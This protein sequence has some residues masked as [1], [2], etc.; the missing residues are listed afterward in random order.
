VIKVG[1]GIANSFPAAPLHFAMGGCYSN[2]S[3]GENEILVDEHDLGTFEP[4][5]VDFP[6][7]DPIPR[8]KID[9]EGEGLVPEGW[10]TTDLAA[11][12]GFLL[13]GG[14]ACVI[15][16][17]EEPQYGAQTAEAQT[18]GAQTA[19]GA[20]EERTEPA[21][22]DATAPSARRVL[23]ALPEWAVDVPRAQ[24]LTR[25]PPGAEWQSLTRLWQVSPVPASGLVTFVFDLPP[26][27]AQSLQMRVRKDAFTDAMA[28]RMHG[29][30]LRLLLCLPT[31]RFW[32]LLRQEL[33]YVD[34]QGS[35]LSILPLGCLLN[36]KGARAAI[37]KAPVVAPELRT[38]VDR[39]DCSLGTS[40]GRNL[41]VDTHAVAALVLGALGAGGRGVAG[42]S[43]GAQDVLA[44]MLRDEPESRIGAGAALCHPWLTSCD[45]DLESAR[46][47]PISRSGSLSCR[48]SMLG[49]HF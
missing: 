36:F 1:R 27:S 44:K 4:L 9:F 47:S 40:R 13:V 23:L 29:N 24:W 11:P 6:I 5:S 12:S 45:V 30:L 16:M 48:R 22:A 17:R 32:G 18:A 35:L 7:D 2:S 21:K 42:L 14:D 26:S 8:K 33:V 10:R 15:E 25:L 31:L 38:A 20:Q 39:N 46:V 34:D 37:H 43:S 28:R 41:G 3:C 49:G 19:E